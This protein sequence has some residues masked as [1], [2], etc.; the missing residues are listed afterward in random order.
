METK[1]DQTGQTQHFII[2]PVFTISEEEFGGVKSEQI[3][4]TGDPVS[5][6]AWLPPMPDLIPLEPSLEVKE[7]EREEERE[8][9][10]WVLDELESL[11]E[12][13]VCSEEITSLPVHSCPRG[14]LL[15]T[16]LIN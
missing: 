12:C 4:G 2:G 3:E 8:V 15:C 7:E 6:P 1:R 5:K 14:H 11:V 9:A 10:G 13:P 16:R